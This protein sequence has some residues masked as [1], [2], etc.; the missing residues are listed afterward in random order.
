MS[1]II[2]GKQI[3]ASW[4]EKLK[5]DIQSIREFTNANRPPCLAIV[6]ANKNPASDVYIRNKVRACKTAGIK[7]R[8]I[9]MNENCRQADLLYLIHKLNTDDSVDAIMVQSPMYE[10]INESAIFDAIAPH[11][12]ADGFNSKNAGMLLENPTNYSLTCL[13]P[14]TPYGIVKMLHSVPVQIAGKHCV[15]IGRSKIVG[16]PLAMML[17]N[18]NATVTV[19]HSKTANLKEICK[20]ADI[21]IVAIGKAKYIT[22]DYV[23]SNA[24]VIDVGMNTDKNGKLCGDVDFE[25]VSKTASAITP[26]PGGVGPMTVAA[27][28]SNTIECWYQHVQ[29]INKDDKFNNYTVSSGYTE[30]LLHYAAPP[31]SGQMQIDTNEFGNFI[32]YSECAKGE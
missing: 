14:C 15:I 7:T 4:R 11:K 22:S 19:C 20:T 29:H 28:L 12:D 16:R 30:L 10:W 23:K 31:I 25:D 26:V 5:E 3:A 18:E 27:L 2:D 9:H 32:G 1:Y 13:K 8:V 6:Q 24:V 21:L 17:L